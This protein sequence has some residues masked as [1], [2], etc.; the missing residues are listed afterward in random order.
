M[1][2][3]Q[4]RVSE[5]LEDGLD[6]PPGDLLGWMSAPPGRVEH[7]LRPIVKR[8]ARILR[9]ENIRMNYNRRNGYFHIEF[10]SPLHGDTV[11]C[12]TVLRLLDPDVKRIMHSAGYEADA[13]WLCQPGRNTNTHGVTYSWAL[14]KLEQ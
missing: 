3:A 1:S 14:E 6:D 8:A 2:R 13:G 9:P 11:Q 7:Y 10:D 5:L 12:Q 4:Q